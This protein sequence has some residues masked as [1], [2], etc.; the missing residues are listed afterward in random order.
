MSDLEWYKSFL[1]KIK[2][3]K[4]WSGSPRVLEICVPN[5]ESIAVSVPDN[6]YIEFQ[7][8]GPLVLEEW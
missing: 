2:K 4:Y 6:T 1:I 7:S 3:M 5:V 8:S